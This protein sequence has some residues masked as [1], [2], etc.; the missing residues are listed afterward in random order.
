MPGPPPI[1][2]AILR[3]RKSWRA[4]INK[5]EPQPDGMMPEPPAFLSDAARV[6]WEKLAVYLND[7]GLLTIIDG[8]DFAMYCQLLAIWI[9]CSQFIQEN[10]MTYE[11][12]DKL[13][14]ASHRRYPQMATLRE[15]TPN[16]LKLSDKLGMNPS[17]RSRIQIDPSRLPKTLDAGG[18]G[19]ESPLRLT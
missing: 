11:V 13:G 6:E 9:E 15:L 14:N 5:L 16:I 1:P 10:G 7:A 19:K 3:A 17:A 2:T 8:N 18:N 4:D 12:H